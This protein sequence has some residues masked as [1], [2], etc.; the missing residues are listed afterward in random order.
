MVLAHQ[1]TVQNLIVDAAYAASDEEAVKRA[2]ER[3]VKAMLFS[4]EAQ[5]TSPVKGTTTFATD[6]A[7]QGPRDQRGRSL[8]DFDLQQRLFR[9]PLSYLV[10][11]A[12]FD[13]L[14]G[15]VKQYVYRRLREVLDGSVSEPE[16]SH[17][18]AGDRA[19][20]LA[21]VEETK[22]DFARALLR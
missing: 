16:F 10:Y 8:R 18:S 9:Y 5:L 21:I 13:A 3:L 1:V 22:P 2:G 7:G 4:G 20:I 14:P 15:P 12:S 17:L 19:A 11:S 6:F